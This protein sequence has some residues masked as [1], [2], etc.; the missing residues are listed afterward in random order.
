MKRVLVA[1]RGEIAVRII[2][3][4]REMGIETVAIYSTEDRDAMHVK[5]ATLAVCVGAA[6]S[7]ESYLNIQNIVSAAVETKC[8][9]VHPG[10]G[11]LSENAHFV[12]TLE[13]CGIK[14]IGPSASS[15]RTMG[16]KARAREVMM[17]CGMPVVPGSDG[18]VDSIREAKRIA[19]DIG[20]PVLIK[21]SAGG[22]GRGMRIAHSPEEIENAFN[23]AKQEAMS[24]FGNDGVYIEKYIVNPKHIELQILAD[25]HGNVVHLGERECSI[26]RR[27]QKIIEEAPA[28]VI[29][30]ALRKKMGEDSVAAAKA[31]GYTNAGTIEFVL[32]KEGNYYFIEMNTRIQVEHPVT[33]MITGI[34]IVREQIRIASGQPLSFAQK[35]IKI[36][37]HAIECRINAEDIH[38]DFMPAPGT[39]S[40]LHFPGGYNTRV[41]SALYSGCKISPHYDSMIAKIIVKGDT[42]MEAIKRMRRALEE[43]LVDGV[44]TNQDFLYLILY[45]FDFVK[46]KYDT[47]FVEKYKDKLI[48]I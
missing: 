7:S 16:D 17:K 38:K 22:G 43:L 8:D 10:F 3:A 28:K 32:D 34:N 30:S 15:I 21:A 36:S 6:P 35:D 23:T 39:V 46:G 48:N 27:N 18:E 33:E 1:N 19:K 2:R 45:N 5:M 9:G 4:C 44:K 29:T 25:E 12:E 20:Y 26:Q 13:Q 42:R 11:F 37:G 14:F 40:F 24:C 41:D 31:A 47:G